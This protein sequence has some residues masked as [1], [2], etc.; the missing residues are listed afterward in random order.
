MLDAMMCARD[1]SADASAGKRERT[2]ARSLREWQTSVCDEARE[3]LYVCC[4][5]GMAVLRWSGHTTQAMNNLV[6]WGENNATLFARPFVILC[7]WQNGSDTMVSLAV[8]GDITCTR[9]GFTHL[10]SARDVTDVA[11]ASI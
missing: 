9:L 1:A 6:S 3:M 5:A 2:G 11:R 4:T 8:Y 7:R 10:A